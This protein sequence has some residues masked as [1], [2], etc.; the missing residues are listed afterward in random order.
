MLELENVSVVYGRKGNEFNALKNINLSIEEGEFLVITGKSGCGKTTLLNV[1][2][3]IKKPS[4]G[5]YYFENE[6]VLVFS[7]K[8]LAIFRN[9]NIGFVVQHFALI[10]N[11]SVRDNVSLPH[12]YRRTP[13]KLIDEKIESALKSLE[14]Y[15]M[16]DKFPYELSGGERQRVAI[17]R[18]IASDPKVIIAD[19]PT[20]ALDEETGHIIVNILKELNNSGK[21]IIL[22]THDLELAERGTRKISMRD[23]IVIS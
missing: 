2:G 15:S 21:T 14:I 6:N 7:D 9:Q 16:I 3:G 22:V 23:G 13:R 19:E 4:S 8:Q 11:R 20:G 18:A 1:I 17:A 5:S 12:I 10:E